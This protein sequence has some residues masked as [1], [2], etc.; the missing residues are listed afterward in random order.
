MP[1]EKTSIVVRTRPLVSEFSEQVFSTDG[2][3]LSCKPCGIKIN[4]SKR[5]SVVQHIR[6]CKH[7][8]SVKRH[9]DKRELTQ[10]LTTRSASTTKKS[11]FNFDL[12]KALVSANI[13]I[14][15]N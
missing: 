9:S 7:N 13:P 4:C 8:C 5:F 10:K 11:T 1:K 6:T 15:K 14:K 2:K 3:I 12:C